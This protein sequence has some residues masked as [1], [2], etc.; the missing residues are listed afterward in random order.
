MPFRFT[1]LE[2]THQF[3]N[4]RLLFVLCLRLRKNVAHLN[5]I[6]FGLR[7]ICVC[8][9]RFFNC[10]FRTKSINKVPVIHVNKVEKTIVSHT[11]MQERPQQLN[12]KI[13]TSCDH[14]RDAI[15]GGFDS[16]EQKCNG[17]SRAV[18]IAWNKI[19]SVCIFF[20][21]KISLYENWLYLNKSIG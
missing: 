19:Y 4:A 20:H 13:K 1:K 5:Q 17:D 11:L 21:L 2:I 18:A 10:D 16:I 14:I 8:T 12:M 7:Y 6:S 15:K 9:L 3:F